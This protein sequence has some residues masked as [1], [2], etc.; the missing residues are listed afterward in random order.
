MT[1]F[2]AYGSLMHPEIFADVTGVRRSPEP[3]LLSGFRRGRLRG[4][5]YP[6][7]VPSPDDRVPGHVY[8]HLPVEAWHR[9]DRF[10]GP[11]YRRA[12]VTVRTDFGRRLSADV[13][14]LTDD[15][16]AE[17]LDAPWSYADFLARDLSRFRREYFGF[18]AVSW[19]DAA[20]D[21]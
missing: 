4:R 7:I 10:E 20:P 17:L 5:S 1:H 6:G 12:P 21:R 15:F 11:M 3:A 14:L 8:V 18:G 16:A 2:F 19:E 9:L 13:Y